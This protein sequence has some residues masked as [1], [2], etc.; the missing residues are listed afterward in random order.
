M[1]THTGETNLTPCVWNMLLISALK[2]LL[3]ILHVSNPRIVQNHMLEKLMIEV[4]DSVCEILPLNSN[5]TIKRY[6]RD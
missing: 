2:G 5:S 1:R 3:L 6:D 4:T